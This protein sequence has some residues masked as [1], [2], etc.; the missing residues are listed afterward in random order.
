MKNVCETVI[1]WKVELDVQVS[2]SIYI[3]LLI[4]VCLK[5][6]KNGNLV[7]IIF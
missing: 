6:K 2:K 5:Q 3:D 4:F 1:W 7:K